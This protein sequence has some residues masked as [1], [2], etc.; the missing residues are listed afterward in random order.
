MPHLD[1]LAGTAVTLAGVLVVHWMGTRSTSD[2]KDEEKPI[3]H[4]GDAP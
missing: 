2:E 4:K 1:L 3:A